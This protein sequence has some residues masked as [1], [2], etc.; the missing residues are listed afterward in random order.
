MVFPKTNGTHVHPSQ[1][2]EITA[3]LLI[4]V[5][6]L[7]IK[8]KQQF[9]G[10]L[11]LLYIIFYAIARSIL[12][13]FRGDKRGFIIDNYLSHSQFIA[14]LILITAIFMYKKLK[15]NNKFNLK[16]LKK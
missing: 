2:Y 5:I 3:L 16:S 15:N 1:L 12:E 13:L 7:Y 4:M 14:I 11:F 10:Q 9:K 8:K 6:L